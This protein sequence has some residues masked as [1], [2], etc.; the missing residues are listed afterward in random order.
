MGQQ[1]DAEKAFRIATNREKE[2]LSLK[3]KWKIS[4]SQSSLILG[5]IIFSGE[6]T[7]RSIL[8]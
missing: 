4:I 3:L 6:T 2:R 8:K 7:T 5:K 1:D